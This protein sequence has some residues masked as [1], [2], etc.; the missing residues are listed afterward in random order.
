MNKLNGSG[1]R[2]MELASESLRQGR[3][4]AIVEVICRVTGRTD[5]EVEEAQGLY[6]DRGS[7]KVYA[8]NTAV[9][10]FDGEDRLLFGAPFQLKSGEWVQKIE[11][12]YD[13]QDYVHHTKEDEKG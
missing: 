10:T 3:E 9:F 12:L 13:R 5:H 8:D 4:K 1:D 11:R 7:F 2:V 6:Q